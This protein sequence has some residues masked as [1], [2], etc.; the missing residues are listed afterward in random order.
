MP[1]KMTGLPSWLDCDERTASRHAL[2]LPA[3]VRSDAAGESEG[4]ITDISSG[5]CRIKLDPPATLGRYLTI[6]L[7]GFPQM[8][9]WVAW[10]RGVEHGVDFAHSLLPE[11]VERFWT[12]VSRM[13]FPRPR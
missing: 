13:D 9:G 7:D 12:D 8:E 1:Q 6:C 4:A 3:M 11:I 10:Q 5:G 2:N